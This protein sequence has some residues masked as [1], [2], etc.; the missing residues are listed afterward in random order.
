MGC[1]EPIYM[2][3]RTNIHY[4]PIICSTDGCT[5]KVYKDGSVF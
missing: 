5:K 4:K 3:R 2:K 1:K